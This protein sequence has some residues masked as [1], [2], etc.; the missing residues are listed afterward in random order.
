MVR[1]KGRFARSRVTSCTRFP[2]WKSTPGTELTRLE[3]SPAQNAAAPPTTTT[4]LFLNMPSDFNGHGPPP[5]YQQIIAETTF[6]RTDVRTVR[7]RFQRWVLPAATSPRSSRDCHSRMSRLF[8][9]IWAVCG[10]LAFGGL[11]FGS[12]VLLQRASPD[13]ALTRASIQL[14]HRLHVRRPR[15]PILLQLLRKAFCL[16][17]GRHLVLGPSWPRGLDRQ[18]LADLC[19][20]S[21]ISGGSF[22]GSI[23]FMWAGNK[24]G[25][26]GTLR[27]ACGF[28]F[29]G[30]IIQTA[31]VNV[32]MLI[33][34]RVLAGLCVGLASSVVPAFQS[35]LAP[36][37]KRGRLV[38]LQVSLGPASALRLFTL[39]GRSSLSNGEL[40]S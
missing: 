11:L 12:V 40:V 36:P 26:L 38:A 14:R 23:L 13:P 32:P 6:A 39:T 10:L 17:A 1:P 22:A 2:R 29:I 7:Q 28:W 4:A 3:G 18:F 15:S 16:A 9:N 30:C 20:R 24:F 25:R 8:S 21:Q 34:G 33:V 19:C 5:T 37:D 31:A 35:E 27:L